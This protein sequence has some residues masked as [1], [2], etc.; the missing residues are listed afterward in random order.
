[1]M[2]ILLNINYA[3]I[4]LGGTFNLLEHR[5]VFKDLHVHKLNVLNHSVY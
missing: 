5:L 3:N 4:I 1:M 2:K